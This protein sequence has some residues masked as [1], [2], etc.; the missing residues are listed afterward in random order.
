MAKA[1][2]EKVVSTHNVKEV[3]EE[4]LKTAPKKKV[5]DFNVSIV[6][7]GV[8]YEAEG[9]D[10]YTLLKDFPA[11][12]LLNTET[13]VRVTKGDKTIQRDIKVAEARRCFNGLETTSLELLSIS[14]NK[15][16]PQ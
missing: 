2:K 11:P 8:S 3:F 1:T 13:N 12:A 16:L 7:S 14:I 10:L 15:Q 5:F 9:N 6:S 4:A